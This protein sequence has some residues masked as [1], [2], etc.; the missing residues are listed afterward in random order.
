VVI[1]RLFRDGDSAVVDI[2]DDGPG[3][4]PA[5]RQ[6]VFE[7][8]YRITRPDS[9]DGSGLGLSIVRVLLDRMGGSVELGEAKRLGGLRVTMRFRLA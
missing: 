2:E 1:A 7:R 6:K 5:E 4:P 3:V 8:F 9:P